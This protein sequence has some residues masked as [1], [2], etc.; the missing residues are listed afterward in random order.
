MRWLA[1]VTLSF[2]SGAIAQTPPVSQSEK[3]YRIGI[4]SPTAPTPQLADAFRRALR[5][6]GYL[7]GKNIIIETRHAHGKPERLPEIVTELIRLNVDVVVSGST[8]GVLAAK[9]TTTTVPIVFA[10]VFD[11][12]GAGIVPSLARPGGNITGVAI[13]VSGEGFGGKWVQLLKDTVPNLSHVTLLWNSTNPSSTTYVRE[14]HAAARVMNVK[15]D[16]LDAGNAASL[17]RALASIGTSRPRGI[18]VTPDPFFHAN[19]TTLVQFFAKER[20]PTIYFSKL[21]IDAGGLMSYGASFED[22]WRKA[23]VYVDKI[24]KGAKPADLPIEQPTKFE[25]VVNL[26]AARTLGLTVPQLVL[27]QADH[28]VE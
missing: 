27:Q 22:S 24:L 19:R 17:D 25:L 20:L 5:E 8:A 14:A 15:I 3:V 7:D 21:F 26:K 2:A 10:S 28:I 23:A 11:P 18:I 9:K 1:A 12:V 13:G 4:I 16:V 6:L